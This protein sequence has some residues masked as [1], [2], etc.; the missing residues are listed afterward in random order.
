MERI[1]IVGKPNSGK[2]LLFN[3]LT[4]LIQKIANFPGVTV[5][6]KQGMFDNYEV[7]DFPGVYSINPL[8]KDEVIAI[9]QFRHEM[10]KDAVKVVVCILDATRLE[11]S[12][13]FG[14]QARREAQK[15]NKAIVFALNMMDEVSTKNINMDIKGL[16]W[17]L[18]TPVFGI[19]S[20]TGEGLV[21]FKR[22]LKSIVAE[23]K[24]FIPAQ[25][26]KT[27]EEI[28]AFSKKLGQRFGAGPNII[29]KDQNKWDR[30]FLHSVSG[31]ASFFLIM[32]F[33]FQSIFTWSAPLM[34]FTE[35]I[36]VT[37]GNGLRE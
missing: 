30:F 31:G 15:Y 13:V 33:L 35:T 26:L 28:L 9:D 1:L 34:D 29:L 36:I 11:R 23:H 24:D 4:G 32:I 17:A 27:D 10:K 2:T 5:E 21:L 12:L 25:T 20:K 8:T 3:R 14:L 7:I 16:E 18:G 22:E 19:S 6:L 37:T